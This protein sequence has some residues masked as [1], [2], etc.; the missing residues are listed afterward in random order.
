M[1]SIV[2]SYVEHT[3][4]AITQLG[5]CSE[6]PAAKVYANGRQL[7]CQFPLLFVKHLL[8]MV[9]VLNFGKE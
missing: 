6:V 2:Q 4:D 8:T 5:K 9:L 1:E 7:W 3:L